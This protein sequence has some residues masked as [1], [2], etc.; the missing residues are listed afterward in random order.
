MGKAGAWKAS[1]CQILHR[2]HELRP[3]ER[4]AAPGGGLG[5]CR[6]SFSAGAFTAG[7]SVCSRRQGVP[8]SPAASPRPRAA[9]AVSWARITPH[10]SSRAAVAGDKPHSTLWCCTAAKG[11]MSPG[12]PPMSPGHPR[13]YIYTRKCGFYPL[14]YYHRKKK[15]GISTT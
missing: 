14:L 3:G 4:E 7:S 12:R 2:Q 6:P 1:E 10:C 9:A 8:G 15:A 11:P 13:V 5:L